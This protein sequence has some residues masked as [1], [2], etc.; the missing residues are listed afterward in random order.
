MGVRILLFCSTEHGM[1]ARPRR[2]AV[3]AN[4]HTERRGAEAQGFE[5]EPTTAQ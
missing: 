1:H 3:N 4:E 2:E 5:A